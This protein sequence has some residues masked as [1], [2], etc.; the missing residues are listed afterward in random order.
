MNNSSLNILGNQNSLFNQFISEIRNSDVQSD[1]L[2]FRRNLERI[3]EIFAY[4]ISKT[5]PYEERE[6]VTPL[7]IANIALL[8]L[9]ILG[10]NGT[11]DH[12]K[13]QRDRG[14]ADNGEQCN[15]YHVHR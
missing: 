10:K 8:F 11:C 12:L 9:G 2:R 15:S 3:G 14:Q 7:G 5:L 4:E 6:I 13:K 1:S